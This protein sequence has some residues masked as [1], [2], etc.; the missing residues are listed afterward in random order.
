M[1]LETRKTPNVKKRI[2][3]SPKAWILYDISTESIS[4]VLFR[5]MNKKWVVGKNSPII[6]RIFGSSSIGKATPHIIDESIRYACGTT[7]EPF[8]K[9]VKAT[10]I[11]DIPMRLN[12]KSTID[13][14]EVIFKFDNKFSLIK[15][16]YKKM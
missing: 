2:D 7:A 14:Y 1:A 3:K 6:W 16:S 15:N 5:I 9:I 4:K 12:I 10:P 13:R 11:K 8:K